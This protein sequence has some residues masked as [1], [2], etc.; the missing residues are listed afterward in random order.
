MTNTHPAKEGGFVRVPRAYLDLNISPG[1]KVLI[2]HLCASADANGESWHSY[3]NIGSIL[4]RSKASISNYVAELVD[5]GL[6]KAFEQKMANGY[7][8]RRRLRL[9]EWRS[10]LTLWKNLTSQ[11]KIREINTEDGMEEVRRAERSLTPLRPKKVARDDTPAL[12]STHAEGVCEVSTKSAERSVQPDECMDPS[13]PNKN[14]EN[15][16]PGA[17][18]PVVWSS[19]DE[20]EWRSFRPDDKDPVATAYGLP[21]DGLITKLTAERERLRMDIGLLEKGTAAIQA[22]DLLQAFCTKHRLQPDPEAFTSAVGCITSMARTTPAIRAAITALNRAWQPHWKRLPTAKQ[23]HD[24]ISAEVVATSPQ[25]H[26]I[27]R[28]VN[29]DHRLWIAALHKSRSTGPSSREGPNPV[30]AASHRCMELA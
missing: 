8:Y 25:A 7:N 23:M 28:I 16:T 19:K 22:H 15:K 29:I 5:L 24:C 18:A 30:V 27:A 20:S 13:G 2:L 6:V 1:A 11:K 4:G 9:T 21:S 26:L 12:E 14:Q 10:F 3:E 17:I